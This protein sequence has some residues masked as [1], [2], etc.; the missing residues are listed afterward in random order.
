M[1]AMFCRLLQLFGA[2][3]GD[4]VGMC[5]QVP[6]KVARLGHVGTL[7][8]GQRADVV[9]MASLA[10]PHVLQ[11]VFVAGKP[12]ALEPAETAGAGSPPAP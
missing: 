4:A 10:A 8:P 11:H 6:A 7:R 12:V 3:L 1:H 9:C 5:S 2:P